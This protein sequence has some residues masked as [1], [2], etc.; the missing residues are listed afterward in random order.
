MCIKV[1]FI[2]KFFKAKQIE[3]VYMY[4][5]PVVLFIFKRNKAVDIIK[6]IAS[7]QPQ[8]L[9]IIADGGRNKE[10]HNECL[11]CRKAVEDAINWECEIVKNYAS[12]NRGV[13]ENIGKGA[14]WVF[15][16]E[17]RAIFLEDDNLPEVTFFEYARELLVYYENEPKI[18]WICGTNYL[19]KYVPPNNESYVFTRCLLPC[20]WASWSHKFLKFYDGRFD[21]F[22][23]NDKITTGKSS[24]I[25]RSVQKQYY[26]F[27]FSEYNRII[28]GLKPLSWDYQMDFSVRSNDLYGISPCLNQI[29][30]IGVDNDSIHGGSSLNDTMTKRFCSI[31]SFKLDTPLHHPETIQIDYEFE[32]R[33]ER[34]LLYPLRLRIK[35]LMILTLRKILKVPYGSSI[36][37]MF[38]K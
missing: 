23:D 31:S 5:I 21:T 6:R 38:R 10:E 34:I 17:E 28:H 13:F 26:R 30:N 4:D 20:G 12:E 3:G 29:R 9:Y 37:T 15:S 27:W 2:S 25:H 19:E 32:R 22:N 7:V 8:K 36:H 35:N 24:F 11:R 14:A 1:N 18:L 16:R 33:M